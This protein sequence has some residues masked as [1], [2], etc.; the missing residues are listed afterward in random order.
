M[1]SEALLNKGD[2]L[3]RLAVAPSSD[4]GDGLQRAA[5]LTASRFARA[6]CFGG[7]LRSLTKARPAHVGGSDRKGNPGSHAAGSHEANPPGNPFRDSLIR[8]HPPKDRR[9]SRHERQRRRG[10][11]A[12][13]HCR[14]SSYGRTRTAPLTARKPPAGFSAA[15]GLPSRRFLNA[16][17]MDHVLTSITFC[18]SR[19]PIKFPLRSYKLALWP[20]AILAPSLSSRKTSPFRMVATFLPV[21]GSTIYPGACSV[22]RVSM[23]HL[24]LRIRRVVPIAVL[25]SA[26]ASRRPDPF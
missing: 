11:G 17:G 3:A 21:S 2:A 6:I 8:F 25:S 16:I 4:H 12:S 26:D 19:R 9:G 24:Q 13:Y 22:L 18:R 7:A 15:I 10:A 14:D 5:A 1:H 23:M 20:M